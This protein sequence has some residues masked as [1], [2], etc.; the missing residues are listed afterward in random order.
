[1]RGA[2][3]ALLVGFLWGSTNPF[4]KRGTRLLQTKLDRIPL[5]CQTIS[6][7]IR[8]WLTTPSFL[9]PYGLNQSG[10]ALFIYLFGSADISVVVPAANACCLVFNTLVDLALGERFRLLPLILGAS[11]VAA[12]VFLC[13][14]SS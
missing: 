9:V 8:V 5:E 7:Q 14:T 2:L 11:L 1:M 10:S 12:G 13:G 6:R 3:A 4:V